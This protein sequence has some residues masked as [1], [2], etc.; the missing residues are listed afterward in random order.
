[1]TAIF[2]ICW[3]IDLFLCTIAIVGKG[4]ANSFHQNSSVPWLSILLVG[5]TVAAFLL[6]V[7][8]KKPV[9]ALSLAALPLAVMLGWYAFEKIT[10]REI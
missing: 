3:I 1:M 2:W 8:F 5:C 4:F 10:G 7:F 9:W 6:Q